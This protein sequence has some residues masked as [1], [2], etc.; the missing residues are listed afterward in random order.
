MSAEPA[1]LHPRSQT[2]GPHPVELER[3]SNFNSKHWQRIAKAKAPRPARQGCQDLHAFSSML[4]LRSSVGRPVFHRALLAG[5]WSPG[6]NVERRLLPGHLARFEQPLFLLELEL[7]D[8]QLVVDLQLGRGGRRERRQG[9]AARAGICRGG[10][11]GVM[12]P[13]KGARRAI[14]ARSSS[15]SLMRASHS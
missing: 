4:F 13:E 14:C 9:V 15:I 11:E 1:A 7:G 3:A 8:A 5:R 2:F 10:G 12:P 6:V